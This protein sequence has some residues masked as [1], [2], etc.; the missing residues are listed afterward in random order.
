[1]PTAETYAPAYKA[2]G[3]PAYSSAVFNF[4]PRTALQFMHA[5]QSGDQAT[6]DALTQK[7]FLPYIRIRARGAGYAVSIVKA[8]V[9]IV[10]RGAGKVRAPLSELTAEETRDL[11]VLI[12]AMGPQD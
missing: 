10:G 12:D 4:I 3:I 6:I 7:F 8:G 2:M 9:N 11:K 1:M 5:L